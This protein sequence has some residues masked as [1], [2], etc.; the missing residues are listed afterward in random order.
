VDVHVVRDHRGERERAGEL[1]QRAQSRAVTAQE[2]SCQLYP[3]PL[4]PER[5]AEGAA[6]LQGRLPIGVDERPVAW[7]AGQ[8]DQALGPLCERRER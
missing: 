5:I 2:R 1:A 6:P 4:G 7:T 8:R 3:Q